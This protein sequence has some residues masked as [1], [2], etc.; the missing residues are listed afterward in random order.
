MKQ[1]IFRYNKEEILDVD[2]PVW[3][4]IE[5][6]IAPNRTSNFYPIVNANYRIIVKIEKIKEKTQ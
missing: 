2:S 4:F 6:T 3:E 1:K 5:D